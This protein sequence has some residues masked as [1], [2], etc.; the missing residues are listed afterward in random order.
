MGKTFY[1]SK[2][3]TQKL[4]D[5]VINYNKQNNPIKLYNG[6]FD[7][8]VETYNEKPVYCDNWYNVINIRKSFEY[9]R[10]E[11][12]INRSKANDKSKEF[13]TRDFDTMKKLRQEEIDEY[14][15]KVK[16]YDPIQGKLKIVEMPPIIW[17]S[18]QT[19]AENY[20][21]NYRFFG[22]VYKEDLKMGAIEKCLRY[23][24]NFSPIS[25]DNAFSYFTT[26]IRHSFIENIK[27]EYSYSNVKSKINT[28]FYQATNEEQC[29]MQESYNGNA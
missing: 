5:S 23:L 29:E 19:I 20:V 22:Y 8:Y 13:A 16:E 21:Q 6:C 26:I 15:N 24:G 4:T 7:Y 2:E 1:M 3:E 25:S 27:K 9:H 18:I 10:I 11:K 28:N 14:I 12:S 17:S